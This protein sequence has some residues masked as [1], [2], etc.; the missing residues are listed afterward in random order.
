MHPVMY[1]CAVLFRGYEALAEMRKLSGVDGVHA[2][3]ENIDHLYGMFTN[4]CT[5][6]CTVSTCIRA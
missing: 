3:D 1:K 2:V 6:L 5:D 4:A